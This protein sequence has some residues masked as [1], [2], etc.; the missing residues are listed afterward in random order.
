VLQRW[1]YRVSQ[2][3]VRL[4]AGGAP[5]DLDLVRCLLPP[6]AFRL[7]TTMPR[8][9]QLHALAV[10]RALR[11]DG[12][13][14]AD[15]AQAALLHDVGKVGGGLTLAHRV[16][17]VLLDWVDPRFV[18]QLGSASGMLPASRG[19]RYPFFV[20]THHAALGAQRCRQA[21]CSATTVALVA[22]HEGTEAENLAEA[23][24][25]RKAQALKQADD[26]C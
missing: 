21:G 25:R 14:D 24:L 3:F 22:S 15:V 20:Q 19:W 23:D 12:V 17:V 5:L 1:H 4:R 16:L 6:V 18:V 26:R 13:Y 10:L 2:F 7:F 11:Q 9:D 8:G